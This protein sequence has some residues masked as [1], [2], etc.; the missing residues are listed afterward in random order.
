MGNGTNDGAVRVSV[1]VGTVE[2][3]EKYPAARSRIHMLS[4]YDMNIR[5]QYGY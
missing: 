2:R 3:K 5:K 1:S 4:D